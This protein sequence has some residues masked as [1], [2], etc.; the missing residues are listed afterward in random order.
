[1]QV[2]RKKAKHDAETRRIV[3]RVK[4]RMRAQDRRFTSK[5]DFERKAVEYAVW[6]AARDGVVLP[7]LYHCDPPIVQWAAVESIVCKGECEPRIRSVVLNGVLIVLPHWDWQPYVIDCSEH[8]TL[9][10]AA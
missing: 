3:A 6:L 7:P 10:L 2:K 8:E 1:M 9:P 5:R 4:A